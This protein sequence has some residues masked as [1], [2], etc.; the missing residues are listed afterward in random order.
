MKTQWWG[1]LE[2][3]HAAQPAPFP[4]PGFWRNVFHKLVR[5]VLSLTLEQSKFLKLA[6]PVVICPTRSYSFLYNMSE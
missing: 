2:D 1:H 4:K 3:S 5:K 6:V